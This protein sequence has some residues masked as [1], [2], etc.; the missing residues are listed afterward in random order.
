MNLEEVKNDVHAFFSFPINTLE[1]LGEGFDSYVFGT[2]DEVLKLICPYEGYS[3][4]ESMVA[5]V[6]GFS[7]MGNIPDLPVPI[8]H[9]HDHGVF[10]YKN[11][12]TPRGRKIEYWL[13][14]SRLE[15]HASTFDEI[16]KSPSAVENLARFLVCLHKQRP[17]TTDQA[18]DGVAEITI[19][20]KEHASTE[21]WAL[22]Q[23]LVDDFYATPQPEQVL[24]HGDMNAHNILL[25]HGQISGIIDFC[26]MRYSE[27]AIDLNP[28]L[29]A[30]EKFYSTFLERYIAHG[31]ERPNTKAVY[32]LGAIRS[33]SSS[34]WEREAGRLEKSI[35]HRERGL[36]LARSAESIVR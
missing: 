20:A 15:G 14:M 35:A 13:R 16:A 1:Y 3:G 5:E 8:P 17:V 28:I 4:E 18:R 2:D 11:R 31:G 23:R 34:I 29:V 27:P 9:L 26:E 24:V 30:S 19:Q 33:L 12:P 6:K 7:L 21:E 10:T 36:S 32:L 25:D 22:M